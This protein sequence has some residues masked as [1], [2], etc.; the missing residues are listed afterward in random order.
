V[1]PLPET[2]QQPR[3]APA[4]PS[5]AYGGGSFFQRHALLHGSAAGR[6]HPPRR[7]LCEANV[8]WP[9]KLQHAVQ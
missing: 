9:P 8:L 6:S 2:A 4:M 5:P 3:F 1:T 7:F